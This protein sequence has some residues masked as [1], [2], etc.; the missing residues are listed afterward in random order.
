MTPPVRVAGPGD[1][2]TVAELLADWRDHMGRDFPQDE[3]IRAGVE[4][5]IVRDDA[6]YL[7]GGEEPAGIVQLRY[8]YGIWLD[9]ED[10]H[11]EDVFVAAEA[12]GTGLG[13][14]LVAFAIERARERG[15][16]RLELDTG[17]DNAPAQ[18]LYRSLG[19]YPSG[20][21]MRR[22]ID[23]NIPDGWG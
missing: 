5:L 3:A 12:R 20:I 4:R 17:E 23:E 15:C 8:R 14:Q 11:V 1:A 2:A 21:F 18:G 10:C 6:E 19:F 16:R 22:R 9:A 7:L 13:K